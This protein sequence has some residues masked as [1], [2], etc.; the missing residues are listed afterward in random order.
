[1][2]IIGIPRGRRRTTH[3]VDLAADSR[4][5]ARANR[6]GTDLPRQIDFDGT[7]D[8]CDLGILADDVDVVRKGRIAEH[9]ARMIIQEIV[10][11][12]SS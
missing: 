2:A 8:R 1:M 7:I 5:D 11:P 12:L 9:H 6:I 3:K 4:I 10:Q